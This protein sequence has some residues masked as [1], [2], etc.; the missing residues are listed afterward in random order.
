MFVIA[1]TN[2]ETDRMWSRSRADDANEMQATEERVYMANALI[3]S[4]D[5]LASGGKIATKPSQ[6]DF[7][8]PLS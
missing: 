7:I 1:R 6:H 8:T 3:T 2:V 5:K 4:V